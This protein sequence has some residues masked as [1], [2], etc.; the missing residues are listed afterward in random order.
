MTNL[1]IM[2]DLIAECGYA[3]FACLSKDEAATWLDEGDFRDNVKN[4]KW[5]RERKEKKNAK[6]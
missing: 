5:H 2:R 4:A 1:E 3:A 6:K